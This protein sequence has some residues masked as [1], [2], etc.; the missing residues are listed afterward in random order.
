[1][2]ASRSY[3]DNAATTWPKPE[4]VY[5]AMD[6]FSREVGANPGRSGHGPSVE[7]ARVVYHARTAIARLFSVPD[8]TRVVF[9]LNCT[10]A[11]NVALTQLTRPGD[12]V[13]T[14]SLEHNSVMRPLRHLESTGRIEIDVIP[15]SP[16]GVFDLTAAERLFRHNTRLVVA[17]HASNVTGAVLPLGELATLAHA[18]GA[19]F[20]VDAAQSGGTVPVDLTVLGVDVL[21]FSGHK[22]L[23]GPQ[24]T[25][26]L[27]LGDGVELE[28]W[29]RGGTGS[30]SGEQVHPSF[31][32]DRLEAGTPN[33][34]GLAGLA[35]GVEYVLN[36]GVSEIHRHEMA[37]VER[38]RE[39]LS[40]IEG[41]QLVPAERPNGQVGLLSFNLTGVPCSE[42]ARE[43][44]ERHGILTRPGLHC[45]PA[46]HQTCGTF[47][48]GA[49]RISVSGLT[50]ETAVRPF[51]AAVAALAREVRR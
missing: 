49:V 8:S 9:T 29:V 13:L 36:R 39:G 33:T 4:S 47:P 25:G 50:D 16:Q 34:P 12:H 3:L 28:A 2:N 46:A 5:R 48:G 19:W 17:V 44:E 15:V 32:P 7:A 31:L 41:V 30:R 21:C 14:T 23:F 45:A 42:V 38:A 37:L 26:G 24:G 27:C 6:R 11:L 18:A 43:L 1:M 10:H 51:V 20:V 22:G 35:A 40:R